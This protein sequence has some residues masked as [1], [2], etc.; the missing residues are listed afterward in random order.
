MLRNTLRAMLLAGIG[1]GAIATV[2]LA[3]SPVK[4]GELVCNVSEVD[5]SILSK[6]LVLACD[7]VDING[8]NAGTYEANLGRTGL[9]LGS[10]ETN[11]IGWL[12]STVGDP[13]DLDLSGT[14]IGATAGASVGS[15]GGANYLTGGF[16]GK[17][18]L[19]PWSAESKK[20]FGLEL[21]G[22]KMV[23]TKASAS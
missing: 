12:V 18:S 11:Q 15:G 6:D 21:G 20:G 14:Y 8:N 13:A 4:A 7:Y 1:A 17:I 3:E 19:Q 9:S 5:G 2:A 23:L 16:N 10:V 22:Q